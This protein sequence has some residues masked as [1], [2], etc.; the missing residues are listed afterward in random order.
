MHHHVLAKKV[1]HLS[2]AIGAERITHSDFT[3]PKLGFSV[4]QLDNGDLSIHFGGDWE[5]KF[6]QY[7]AGSAYYLIQ[8][9]NSKT[10][11]HVQHDK[12]GELTA[13]K[14]SRRGNITYKYDPLG[15]LL[16]ASSRLGQE[17]FNFDPASNI[18]I[19]TMMSKVINKKERAKV[20]AIIVLLTTWL[21]NI[22]ISNTNM[23]HTDN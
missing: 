4:E 5:F 20:M 14:D 18:L 9:S 8:Q 7:Q 1:V 22:L 2:Y 21:K 17:I 6:H 13:I 23:M 19:I 11:E 3:V 12:T 10:K 15:R 16:E